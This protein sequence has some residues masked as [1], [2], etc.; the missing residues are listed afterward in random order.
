MKKRGVLSEEDYQMQL[1]AAA[2]NRQNNSEEDD[3][4]RID[5]FKNSVD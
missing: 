1:Q 4:H 5:E 2:L 3:K